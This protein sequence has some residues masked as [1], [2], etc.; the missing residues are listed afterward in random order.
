MRSKSDCARW[1]GLAAVLALCQA[2]AFAGRPF[3]TEDAGVIGKGSCEVEAFAERLRLSNAPNERGVSAQLS[4]GV[5]GAT[6]LGLALAE[7]KVAGENSRAMVFSGK[8]QLVDGG[9]NKASFALAYFTAREREPNQS[10]RSVA[11]G[12]NAVVTTPVYDWLVH[13]NLG[14]T[15]ER[16]PNR[17]VTGWAVAFE[18]PAAVKG[19]DAGFEFFGDDHDTRWAQIAARWHFLPERL[20]FDASLGKQTSGGSVNRLSVGLKWIF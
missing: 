4:C 20:L 3:S 8:T 12:V 7:S 18:R 19:I 16:G 17:T 14:V 6:Q 15:A 10:W 11:S 5:I 9:E 13:A 2:P 1:R